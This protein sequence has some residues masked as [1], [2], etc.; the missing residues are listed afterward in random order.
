MLVFLVW[1]AFILFQ[2]QKKILQSHKR[3]CQNKEFCN[4]IMPSENT[5]I[6]GFNQYQKSDKVPF[7]IYVDL[8]CIIENIDEC[9]NIPENLSTT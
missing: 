8:E 7:I 9:K 2:Q 6:L 1:I 3:V 5:K 4:I